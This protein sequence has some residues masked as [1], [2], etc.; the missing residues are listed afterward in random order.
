[1]NKLLFFSDSHLPRGIRWHTIPE[2]TRYAKKAF[3]PGGSPIYKST[4]ESIIFQYKERIIKNGNKLARNGIE[5]KLGKKPLSEISNK[6]VLGWY[7]YRNVIHPKFFAEAL[8]VLAD[9]S[10]DLGLKPENVLLTKLNRDSIAQ[11]LK[12]PIKPDDIGIHFD[13]FGQKSP[14]EK[15]EIL[16]RL[17]VINIKEEPVQEEA[18]PELRPQIEKIDPHQAKYAMVKALADHVEAKALLLEMIDLMNIS[19]SSS[20]KGALLQAALKSFERPDI[21]ELLWNT[22]ESLHSMGATDIS[23]K[24]RLVDKKVILELKAR[25]IQEK[26]ESISITLLGRQEQQ[27]MDL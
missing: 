6:R 9:Q 16:K 21:K 11:A 18:A 2:R 23:A 12:G 1:M 13:K 27:E 14:E 10:Q 5:L 8:A 25:P 26:I 17:G 7:L 3:F 19:I 22:I 20:V 15:I 4:I 24:L